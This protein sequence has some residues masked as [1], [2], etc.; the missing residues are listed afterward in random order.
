MERSIAGGSLTE[1][2]P[3][4]AEGFGMTVRGCG[5]GGKEKEG[6]GKAA[7]LFL[8]PSYVSPSS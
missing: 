1:F 3:S 5:G 6:C 7:S 2:I 8:S 4:E